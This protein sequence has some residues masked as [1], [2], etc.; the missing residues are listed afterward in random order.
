[1]AAAE[2]QDLITRVGNCQVYVKPCH[3]KRTRGG[4]FLTCAGDGWRD[5]GCLIGSA[6]NL[7]EDVRARMDEEVRIA[8]KAKSMIFFPH[9]D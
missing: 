8:K 9:P 1:V 5:D 3:W 2:L 7:I 4:R 6:D